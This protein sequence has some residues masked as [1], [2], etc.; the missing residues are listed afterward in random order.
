MVNLDMFFI[1]YRLRRFVSW[2]AKEELFKN[3][4]FSSFI[5]WVGAFPV[6]RGTGDIGSVKT[7]L[8]LIEE[9]HISWNVSGRNTG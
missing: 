5:R 7:V 3:P 9:G 8:K 4:V 6:K 2:M 1:G